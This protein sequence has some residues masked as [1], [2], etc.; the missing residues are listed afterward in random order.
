MALTKVEKEKFSL[1][2]NGR[3]K[4][5]VVWRAATRSE[6]VSQIPR[7]FEG[8]PLSSANGTP[9]IS[10]QGDYL[11]NASYEG[12]SVDPTEEDD[13]YEITTELREEKLESFPNRGLL[14]EEFGAFEED[15]VLKFPPS[16]PKSSSLLSGLSLDSFNDGGVEDPNPLFNV[17][18]YPV[19]YEVARW[20]LLRKRVPGS[21]V[22]LLKTVQRRLPAGFDYQGPAEAWYVRSVRRSKTSR[23][24]Y[25]DI[26]VEYMSVDEF[27]HL[28]ALYLLNEQ[29]RR[30]GL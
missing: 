13:N 8:M 14:E 27:A 28:E 24:G 22:N 17:S 6:A 4:W 3:I 16:L 20:R 25:W 18:T 11:V 12:L 26:S 2:P 5:D 9:R 1:Q 7:T 19:E 29:N 30:T 15:G 23:R 21:I 10:E